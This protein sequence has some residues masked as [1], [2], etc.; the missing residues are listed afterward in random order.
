MSTI[1]R[2]PADLAN[3]TLDQVENLYVGK[4]N[5]CRCGCGGDYFEPAE[6]GKKILRSLKKFN[7]GKYSVSVQS[8]YIF[9]I[10]ISEREA[11][12]GRI[13]TRVHTLYLKK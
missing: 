12:Y 5:N 6:H 4:G 11:G 9:E 3:I 2:T 13:Q 7:S 1:T 10:V 8:G